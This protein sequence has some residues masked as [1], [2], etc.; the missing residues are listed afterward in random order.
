M[1]KEKLQEKYKDLFEPQIIFRGRDYFKNNKVSS[2]YK[3]TDTQSY[4]A[5][6]EGSGFWN[7]L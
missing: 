7:T 2:L 3:E 5:K 6:V 4:I 1:I